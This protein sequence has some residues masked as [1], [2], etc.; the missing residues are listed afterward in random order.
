MGKTTFGFLLGFATACGV[1]YM[2]YRGLL[3]IPEVEAEGK[4]P[5]KIEPMR[6]GH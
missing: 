3:A 1:A 4:R 2:A 6:R 5:A